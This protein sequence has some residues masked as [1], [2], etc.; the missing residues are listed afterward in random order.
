M[1]DWIILLVF[2]IFGIIGYQLVGMIDRLLGHDPAD[3][4]KQEREKG[5]NEPAEAGETKRTHS[6]MPVFLNL[7]RKSH[8]R[9]V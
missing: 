6:C 4:E 3:S 7:Q 9:G 8:T 2:A 5:Q 1:K